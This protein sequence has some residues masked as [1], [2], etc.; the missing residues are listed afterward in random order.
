M[1]NSRDNKSNGK[2]NLNEQ[3]PKDK[4]NFDFLYIK[5]HFLGIIIVGGIVNFILFVA[6]FYIKTEKALFVTGFIVI[7][8]SI[9]LLSYLLFKIQSKKYKYRVF[10]GCICS[11]L[12]ISFLFYFLFPNAVFQRAISNMCENP[13]TLYEHFKCPNPEVDYESI[14]RF[15]SITSSDTNII[16]NLNSYKY[17]TQLYLDFNANS[18]FIGYY[19]PA[20]S[21]T[22]LICQVLASKT[23]T[24]VNELKYKRIRIQVNEKEKKDL[25]FS[26]QV[27]LYNETQLFKNE[28][29]VIKELFKQ[30]N[31][32]IDFR[33]NE[34]FK[35]NHPKTLITAPNP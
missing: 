2:P 12:L 10:G 6:N 20:N 24:I 21:N 4:F 34:Y 33:D 11:I 7:I 8:F 1:D 29:E 9:A 31:L 28:T 26:R 23:D 22:K 32:N 30:H 15:M 19:L 16:K 18:C 25:I 5:K 3:K 17:F 14:H 27:Y 13:Q 35:N